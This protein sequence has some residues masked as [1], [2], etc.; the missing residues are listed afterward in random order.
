MITCMKSVHYYMVDTE[1]VPVTLFP[2]VQQMQ[3]LEANTP[4]IFQAEYNLGLIS[5][6]IWGGHP[7]IP[8]P[9]PPPKKK[10]KKK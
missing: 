1:I 10:K 5:Y 6:W 3:Y 2:I 4:I 9:P 7:W 8:P